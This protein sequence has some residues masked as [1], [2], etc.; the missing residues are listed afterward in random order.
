MALDGTIV[1]MPAPVNPPQIPTTSSVGLSHLHA[2]I[3]SEEI[4]EQNSEFVYP[5][6]AKNS[7]MHILPVQ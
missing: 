1:L 6:Y 5:Y 4:P 7:I 3:S 2:Y